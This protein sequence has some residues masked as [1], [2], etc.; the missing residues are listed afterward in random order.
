MKQFKCNLVIATSFC[1]VLGCLA[2]SGCAIDG[3]SDAARSVA[4]ASDRLPTGRNAPISITQPERWVGTQ[5]EL[6]ADTWED[7]GEAN[8]TKQVPA[9]Y[10]AR[11]ISAQNDKG[12]PAA[13]VKLN[14]DDT[15]IPDLR[16]VGFDLADKRAY[17]LTVKSHNA[18]AITKAMKERGV[19]N[20]NFG[21]L[22]PPATLD[23]SSGRSLA[24]ASPSESETWSDGVDTRTRRA[25]V[26]GY[27]SSAW[28]ERTMGQLQ[29]DSFICS[30]TLVGRRVVLTAAHCV[31][32]NALDGWNPIYNTFAARRD[33]NA[34]FPY[35]DIGAIW[36]W[37]PDGY[38]NHNCANPGD[39]NKYDFAVMVLADDWG[40]HPGWSGYEI[41]P[42]L[43]TNTFMM[44][45]Y[46]GCGAPEE[47][48]FCTNAA[49]Y[50]DVEYCNFGSF[51][52]WDPNYPRELT[53]SCDAGRGMSGSGV[54]RWN[55]IFP[56][57]IG[58]YNH[59]WCV[60][61]SC[62]GNHYPNVT[63]LITS[64]YASA[65]DYFNAAYP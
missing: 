13:G 14:V 50:G 62:V 57:V 20:S 63:G 49:L 31:V 29:S 2:A 10:L 48:A 25:T 52:S 60:A 56:S 42:G 28:P 40:T 46:P 11:E 43:F 19:R 65:I 26:D 4:Q 5:L 59:S 37:V 16:F 7:L 47:P 30:G 45:G 8:V 36:Y 9:D 1:S 32:N 17:R 21:D 34:G 18:Q 22:P 54:W 64:E 15:D 3:E 55:W 61:T 39:C 23:M 51:S 24:V 58:Q 12:I 33:P 41:L 35:G 44:E 6:D 27:S 38:L 53:V